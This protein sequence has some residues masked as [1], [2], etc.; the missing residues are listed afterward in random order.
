M[1]GDSDPRVRFQLL[2]T[3]GSVSTPAAQSARDRLL[4][5]DFGDKWTEIAALSASPEEASRLLTLAQQKQAPASFFRQA[6]AVI[7]ARRRPAEM[8]SVLSAVSAD[9]ASDRRVATLEGLAAGL[10]SSDG[11]VAP[12]VEGQL[13][14]M[15]E[16][17]DPAVRHAALQVLQRVGVRGP[18]ATAAVRRAE[19]IIGD[20]SADAELRADSIGFLALSGPAPRRAM[21]EGLIQ[22]AEP[23]AVQVAAI[24]ALGQIPGEDAG[25]FLL[26]HWRGFTA[27]ARLEAADALYRDPNRIP[28]VL[29]ALKSGDI[30][31]WTLAF[32]H[33]RQLVMH[34]DPQIRE[35]ARQL[36]ESGQSERATVIAQYQPAL[37][38]AGDATRG[39]TVFRSICAKCHKLDGFGAE[40][41]P[42]LATIRH[43][44][45][46]VLLADVLDPNKSISQGFEAYVVETASGG[47][48][49]G[50]LG[51]QTATTLTLRHEEGKQDVIPRKDIKNMYV[52]NLSAMPA[53]L[54]KQIS[55]QQMADLLAYVKANH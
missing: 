3:L 30:Q 35:A 52:T 23:E 5:A 12:A 49:D 8:Q 9:S 44:P 7:G 10:R 48:I 36:L 33:R 20:A 40:V 27:A 34:R 47:S 26:K 50:V 29:G 55:V 43:Q 38:Q 16:Q 24:R 45:K 21:L 25:R 6:A 19:A 53:D 32:R 2:C 31:P 17:G 1:D 39:R 18:Q 28:M 41:G 42:D 13:V 22:P 51:P 4:A 14:R 46:Q 54:E 15:F 37:A 11:A